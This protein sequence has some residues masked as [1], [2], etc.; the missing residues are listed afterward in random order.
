MATPISSSLATIDWRSELTRLWEHSLTSL[1]LELPEDSPMFKDAVQDFYS[2][3]NAIEVLL[4]DNED[5]RSMAVDTAAIVGRLDVIQALIQNCSNSENLRGRAV[6]VVAR[7]GRLDIL[8]ELVQNPIPEDHRGFA[9]V[10]A[11][12][13]NSFEIIQKLFE[14]GS[15]SR[16]LL[17]RA[18]KTAEERS[19]QPIVN[20]L[21]QIK[22][23]D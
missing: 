13:H 10:E 9:A 17:E 20:F 7:N 18:I 4:Q 16:V 11:A 21:H 15:T 19:F 22:P 12:R 1:G 14:K 2:R 6:V 3:T 5:L 8:H 23:I